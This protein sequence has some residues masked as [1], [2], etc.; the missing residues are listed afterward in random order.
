MFSHVFNVNIGVSGARFEIN[1]TK[2][3]SLIKEIAIYVSPGKVC[4]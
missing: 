2:G 3:M 1:R 4:R